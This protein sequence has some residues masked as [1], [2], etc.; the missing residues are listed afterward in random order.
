VTLPCLLNRESTI[1]DWRNDPR[2]KDMFQPMYD[3]MVQ[4]MRSAMGS[5]DD[6]SEFIGM[7]I[8]KFFLEMPLLSILQFQEGFLPKPA[9]EI[10]DELLQQVHNK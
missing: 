6:G 1:R 4:G 9:I 3:M 2:G 8:E 10:V 7:D 5:G